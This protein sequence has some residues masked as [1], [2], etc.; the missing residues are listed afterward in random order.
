MMN[1]DND[2]DGEL[3][4]VMSKKKK[5]NPSTPNWKMI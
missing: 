5:K 2:C 4:T 3:T 1:N